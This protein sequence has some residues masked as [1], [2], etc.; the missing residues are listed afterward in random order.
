MELNTSPN[1]FSIQSSSRK[2]VY[3]VDLIKEFLPENFPEMYERFKKLK[4]DMES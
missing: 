1:R 4:Q 2:N 3:K